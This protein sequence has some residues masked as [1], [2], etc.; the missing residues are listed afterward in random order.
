MKF[1]F[2]KWCLIVIAILSAISVVCALILEEV[3]MRA[4]ICSEVETI[5]LALFIAL[6]LD[7]KGNNNDEEDN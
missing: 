4:Y 7:E 1:N 3:S 6:I 5:I 2:Y